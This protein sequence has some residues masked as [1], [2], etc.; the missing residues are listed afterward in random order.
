MFHVFNERSFFDFA[1]NSVELFCETD[2]FMC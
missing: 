1:P 2:V